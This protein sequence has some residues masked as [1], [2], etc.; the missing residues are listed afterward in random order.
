MCLF[1]CVHVCS[2]ISVQKRLSLKH[3]DGYRHGVHKKLRVIFIQ[4][5]LYIKI[6]LSLNERDLQVLVNRKWHHP[7]TQGPLGVL[8]LIQLKSSES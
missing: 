8:F 7:K 1:M 2:F 3:V 4:Y 6:I 5:L